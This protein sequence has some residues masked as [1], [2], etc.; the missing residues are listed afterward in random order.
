VTKSPAYQWYPKDIL[1][2]ARVQEMSLA[3]EGAY[4]RLLDYCWLNGS[5]PSDE[6]RCAR[7]IGKGA[8]PEM[9]KYILEMFIPHPTDPDKKIHD[10]LESERIKQESNSK[11]RKLAAEARWDKQGKSADVRGKQAMSESVTIS[12]ANEYANALQMQSLST[13]TPVKKRNTKVFQKPTRSEIEAYF[14]ERKST[15]E[16]AHDFE[17]HYDSNGWKV[18]RNKMADWK[19]SARNW[20]KNDFKPKTAPSLNGSHERKFVH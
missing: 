3:E 20:L 2:S 6:R 11:V 1:A 13:A 14:L 15:L 8:T 4:R 18:G 5:V 10:R 7:L 9:A 17:D 12:D 19:A 16:E